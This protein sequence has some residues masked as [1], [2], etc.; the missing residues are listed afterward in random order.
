MRQPR[1]IKPLT[2]GQAVRG[3]V[4]E[5][6]MKDPA[7]ATRYNFN[8]SLLRNELNELNKAQNYRT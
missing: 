3:I 7:L 1:K 4:A 2:V 8:T 5:A 6:I